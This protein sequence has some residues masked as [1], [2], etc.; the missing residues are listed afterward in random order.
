MRTSGAKLFAEL[1]KIFNMNFLTS[2]KRSIPDSV[3]RKLRQGTSKSRLASALGPFLPEV[4][5]V[6]VGA[7]YYPHGTWHVLLEAPATR[8]IAVE[9]NSH[10]LGYVKTWPYPSQIHAVNIGLSEHGG[11]QTLFVTNVDS[12]SSLLEPVIGESMRRRVRNLEYFFPIQR[13]TID[14][15]TLAS[16]LSQYSQPS[17]IMPAFVKLDTQGAELSILRGAHDWLAQHRIVGVELEAT[18]QADP[19]MRGAGKFWEACEYFESLGYELLEIK[20]IF[21]PSRFGH[22]RARG[23]T[24]LNECDAVFVLRQ[25][26]AATCP[27][28]Y[29]MSLLAFY[30]CYRH[31]EEGIS[32]LD[33]DAEV[34]ENLR[35]RGCDVERLRRLMCSL[36]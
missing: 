14:T 32:L 33:E 17:Q 34:L 36:A 22:S 25:D 11:A 21:G 23:R 7:S 28:E 31:Y 30:L 35:A 13:K 15:R 3:K 26:V 9:P 10:N 29:R 2:L 5:C 19:I 4:L 8:W 12:G 18:M 1:K 20:P 6:D 16:V 27:T 24:F